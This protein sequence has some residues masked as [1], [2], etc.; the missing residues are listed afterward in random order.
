L[1]KSSVSAELENL[2][3]S[4]Y[5]EDVITKM[6]FFQGKEFIYSL[7]EKLPLFLLFGEATGAL[8][9]FDFSTL[10]K[11]KTDTFLKQISRKTKGEIQSYIRQI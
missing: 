2:F 7:N 6:K 1:I 3:I 11:H 8:S 9:M 4:I 5:G 10:K